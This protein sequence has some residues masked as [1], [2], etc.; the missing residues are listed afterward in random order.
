MPVPESTIT[1][2]ALARVQ[3]AL[4]QDKIPVKKDIA[5]LESLETEEANKILDQVD[6]LQ[7]QKLRQQT[8]QK[9][10]VVSPLTQSSSRQSNQSFEAQDHF[11]GGSSA[12][13]T[14]RKRV[15][16]GREKD[17]FQFFERRFGPLIVLI[18]YFAMADLEKAV[19]YAPSPSECKELAPHLARIGPKAEDLLHLPKWAHEAIVTSD[20]TFT[21]G[22]VLVGY[23]D[24]IGVLEKIMPWMT[25]WV[26]RSRKLSE[27]QTKPETSTGNISANGVGGG[28]DQQFPTLDQLGVTGIGL[29]DRAET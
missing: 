16:S 14:E 10:T 13:I 20:S 15:L 5:I 28:V 21:V 11:A 18:L 17:Y 19:F 8:S 24:R 22:M 23:L 3:Q 2:N 1:R 4:Q 9:S 26:E 29:Q 27:Q 12:P 6:E 7:R 25:S